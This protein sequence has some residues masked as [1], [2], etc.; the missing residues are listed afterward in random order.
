MP[1][2]AVIDEKTLC[3]HGGLSPDLQNLDQ[4]KNIR[5]P[6][7]VPGS[8]L[9]CDLLWSGRHKDVKGWVMN[10]RGISCTF[11]ADIVE[12]FVTK[13]DLDLI[14]RSYQ[15]P[16]NGYEFFADKRM[17]TIFSASNF[18]GLYNNAAGMMTI[19]EDR[20][21]SFLVLYP[22]Q[23]IQS[24]PH[25]SAL[26]SSSS[27]P[28]IKSFGAKKLAAAA[29]GGPE[30]GSKVANQA[31]GRRREASLS[32]I[33]ITTPR[34]LPH[35]NV[36]QGNS[37]LMS[38]AAP[39]ITP[40]AH[41]KQGSSALKSVAR[42]VE[43]RGQVEQGTSRPVTPPAS[44][45]QETS[46]VKRV[47]TPEKTARSVSPFGV[48][49][50]RS[51]TPPRPQT[52]FPMSME[53]ELLEDIINRLLDARKQPGKAVQL[54]EGEIRHLSVVSR[55]IFLS[56]PVLLELQAPIKLCGDIHGQFPDLLRLFEFSGFPPSVQY[57]F[58]GNYVDYGKQSIETYMSASCIQD[59]ISR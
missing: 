22:P 16:K 11:G 51:K 43:P 23:K 3:L 9:L 30:K 12:E 34:T 15:V 36:I 42:Q 50:E 55:Q 8:G 20:S 6:T 49:C 2:A 53:M 46:P 7:D 29:A 38:N 31:L 26:G 59:Q 17:V 37:G 54:S 33:G 40:R 27:S 24:F 56:Q 47:P 18:R 25:L 58:M 28:P 10:R 52:P 32:P 45:R 39:V 35:K 48:D 57:L 19:N 13:H 21:W 4:I 41:V 44:L 14:C 1:V 5:R